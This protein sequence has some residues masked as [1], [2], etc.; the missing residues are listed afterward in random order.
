MDNKMFF[1]VLYNSHDNCV[2]CVERCHEMNKKKK[3]IYIQEKKISISK[4]IRNLMM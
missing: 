3:T 4:K 2:R 1:F